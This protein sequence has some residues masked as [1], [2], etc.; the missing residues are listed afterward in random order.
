MK[1]IELRAE[2]VKRLR[3]IRIRPS[4][5]GVVIT[6]RNGQGK[7][8]ALD[9]IWMALGG[10]DAAPPD[11]VRH[12]ETKARVVLDLGAFMVE[13]RW[14]QPDPAK[15][16]TTSLHV[17]GKDGAKYATPQAVLDRLCGH[18]AFDPL[19]FSRLG[20]REQRAQ[21]LKAVGAE[22]EM[23]KL[24]A[25]RRAAYDDRTA[26]NRRLDDL[27]GLLASIKIPPDVTCR[28]TTTPTD[29]LAAEM[30]AGVDAR[31][32]RDAMA[33]EAER[34]R[35]LAEQWSTEAAALV[36]RAVEV[37][38]MA[39]ESAR[40][41]EAIANEAQKIQVPDVTAIKDRMS[42]AQAAERLAALW[43]QRADAATRITKGEAYVADLTKQ[44]EACDAEKL[45]ILQRAK[46]PVP[47]VSVSD[48]CV[49][50]NGTPLVQCAAS[51]QLRISCAVA[52]ALN[53]RV[54]VILVR[55]ASLLD[56]DGMRT[57]QEMA[58]TAPGGDADEGGYQLWIERV[59]RRDEPVGVVIEDG[60][61]IA[62]DGVPAPK[63]EPEPTVRGGGKRDD[64]L[65]DEPF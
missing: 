34:R 54:R 6:G 17:T 40:A 58:K 57:L 45:A 26:G 50:V 35:A 27:R 23:A 16:A 59:G 48:S 19:E 52:M 39:E 21:L 14:N 12:G 28:P 20:P 30:Q 24:D 1:I 15:D 43:D 64:G 53:P 47:G 4:K 37:Q 29:Q 7:S 65:G 11:P 42:A 61:V 5:D 46:V 56:D 60:E 38:K 63:V 2:N 31:A 18:L 49:L 3:A 13:R 62:V 32:K 33:A 9:A 51:E 10:K 44:I 22:G 55:D 36:K 8:S 25:R 41:A